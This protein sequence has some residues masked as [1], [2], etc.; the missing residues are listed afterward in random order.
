[1][2]APKPGSPEWRRI[3][4]ASKVPAILGISPWESPLSMWHRMRGDVPADRSQSSSQSRGQ[5]LEAGVLDWFA[6]DHPEL[7]EIGRQVTYWSGDWCLATTDAAYTDDHGALV[8]CEAKTT[9]HADEWGQP[10]TDEIPAHYAAQVYLQLELSQAERAHVTMLGPFLDRKDYLIIAD[11]AL[12]RSI[13]DRCRQF[14]ASLD[15]DV[16][17]PLDDHVATVNVLRQLHPDIERGETVQVDPADAR[18]W[19]DAAAAIKDAQKAERAAKARIL[20]AMKR[21][22]YAEAGG[23][24]VG[25]RQPGKYGVSLIATAKPDDLTIIKETA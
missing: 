10:G 24:R 2:T 18:E 15:Q 11:P 4:S 21:A 16:P 8:L 1:M 19:L 22:Q 3:V 13:L 9:A 5:F 14:Y 7:S 6:A 12:Q 17:P 20:N 23:V 25:R